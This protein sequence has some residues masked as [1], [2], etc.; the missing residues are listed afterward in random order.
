M[1]RL[2]TS[3]HK[4]HWLRRQ[5]VIL[6]CFDRCSTG[7][8]ARIRIENTR[9]K[10][11]P[12]LLGMDQGIACAN[13][14]YHSGLICGGVFRGLAAVQSSGSLRRSS[15]ERTR[16]KNTNTMNRNPMISLIV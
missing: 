9:A 14:K 12:N 10:T 11:P 4:R 8:K 3:N 7:N 1:S 6:C 13:R 16:D 2:A 15:E 5:N